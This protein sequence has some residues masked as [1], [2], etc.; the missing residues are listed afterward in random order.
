MKAANETDW[1]RIA[2]YLTSRAKARR[3]F[4]GD[5]EELY[6]MALYAV[7]ICAA[8]YEPSRNPSGTVGS[9]C[10]GMGWNR[11]R[12]EIRKVNRQIRLGRRFAS[13]DAPSGESE[14]TI[15]EVLERCEPGMATVDRECIDLA[16]AVA[17]QGPRERDIL[18]ARA[19]GFTLEEAAIRAGVSKSTV[20]YVCHKFGKSLKTAPRD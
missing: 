4:Y 15:R 5:D 18:L 3:M 1:L 20:S 16:A 8:T 14:I 6:E 13:Y 2:K 17:R 7:G 9:F 10:C 12:H 19:A 11:L